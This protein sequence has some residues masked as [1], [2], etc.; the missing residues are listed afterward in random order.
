MYPSI[1]IQR[2]ERDVEELRNNNNTEKMIKPMNEFLDAP[3][4]AT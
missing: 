4:N 2:A 3:M 1:H